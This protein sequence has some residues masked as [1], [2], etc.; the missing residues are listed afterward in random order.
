MSVPS[1][2]LINGNRY[3]YA[4]IEIQVPSIGKRYIG[5]NSINYSDSLD[6]G[7]A[8]GTGMM[9]IGRTAGKHDPSADLEM[10]VQEADDFLQALTLTGGD[11]ALLKSAGFGLIPFGIQVQYSE[12]GSPV[13]TDV[14]E[15][16]RIT[17]ADKKR[18]QGT[19]ALVVAFKLDVMRIKH[20]GLYM[21]NAPN[22]VGTS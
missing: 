22:M 3:S 6:P 1:V 17:G 14:I 12:V 19:D 9:K 18:G 21:F 11:N 13:I 8:W 2:P 16:C 20:N 10:Y 4:S 7:K 15:G 5:I